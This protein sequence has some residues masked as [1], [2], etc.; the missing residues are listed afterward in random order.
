M[1]YPASTVTAGVT[2]GALGQRGY[3]HRACL[4]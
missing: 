1:G 3:N 2:T 4:Q